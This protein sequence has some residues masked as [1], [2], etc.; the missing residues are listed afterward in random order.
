MYEDVLKLSGLD[1]KQVK[2]YLSA[3]ELGVATAAQ[4]SQHSG[5]KRTTVY[6][7]IDELVDLGV[8]SV[9]YKNKVKYFKAQ[10]PKVLIN[11]LEERRKKISSIIPKLEE[12]FYD[13]NL[14][15]KIEFAT[16]KEAMKNILLDSLNCKTKKIY[17]IV[18]VKEWNKVFD[19]EFTKHYIEERVKRGIW[20]YAIHPVS[21]DIYEDPYAKESDRY[22]RKVKYLPKDMF[23]AS[24]I[25]IYDNKLSMISTSKEKFG[26]II[27]SGE[28]TRTIKKYFEF[29]W[30]VGVK[31]Y[32]EVDN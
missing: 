20:A 8:L 2:A 3:L 4:I 17:Q 16:G 23:Y 22:K 10:H 7:V 11:I 31:S 5:I 12:K 13:L 18:K 25:T 24:F 1:D 9:V 26:F 29:M 14:T 32:E 28:F 21:S 6:G 30:R 19:K 27:E 15:P